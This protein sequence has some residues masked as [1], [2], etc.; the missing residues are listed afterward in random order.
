MGSGE[1]FIV[2]DGIDASGKTTQTKLLVK[3][4]KKRGFRVLCRIHPSTDNFFGLKTKYYLSKEGQTAHLGAAFY[5]MLDVLRSTLIYCW[6]KGTIKVFARYLMGTAYLPKPAHEAVYLFFASTLPSSNLMFILD[7]TPEEAHR[8][9][10]SREE[11]TEMF[12]SLEQLREIRVRILRLAKRYGWIIIKAEKHELEIHKEI[13][14]CL[15][16]KTG[17]NLS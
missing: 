10:K 11:K 15:T 12:E 13:R 14:R 3:C 2:I 7:I 5:Y 17:L 1:T 8:R 6:R 16:E 9:L 4:L